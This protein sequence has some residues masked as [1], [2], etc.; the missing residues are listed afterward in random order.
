MLM[1]TRKPIPEPSAP[2]G[3]QRLISV[4]LWIAYATPMPIMIRSEKDNEKTLFHVEALM[5]KGDG[6]S[7][8]ED[9]LLQLLAK[10]AADFEASHYDFGTHGHDTIADS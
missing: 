5:E 6:R 3:K 7:P 8:D 4:P 2:N 9:R 10:L 1:V